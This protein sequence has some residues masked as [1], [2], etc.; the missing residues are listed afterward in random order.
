VKEASYRDQVDRL[1]A[2]RA[3]LEKR[4]AEALRAAARLEREA[5]RIERRV[6]RTSDAEELERVLAEAAPIRGQARQRRHE[7]ARI[8]KQ[9]AHPQETLERVR[10]TRPVWRTLEGS[11]RAP[12]A[13]RSAA[14]ASVPRRVEPLRARLTVLFAAADPF[15]DYRLA[16]AQEVETVGDRLQVAGVSDRVALHQVCA[17]RTPDL[18]AALVGLRPQVLHLSGHAA[19]GRQVAFLD[20]QGTMKRLP[21]RAIGATLATVD[22]EIEIV[23]LAPSYAAAGA[24]EIAEQVPVVIALPVQIGIEAERAFAAALYTALGRGGSISQGFDH[25]RSALAAAGIPSSRLP[26]LFT[27]P[28]V[29]AEELAL[30][31]EPPHGTAEAA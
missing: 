24:A 25:A 20:A 5:G 10:R 22:D 30:V 2:A 3:G 7:A 12:I 6:K 21:G 19:S 26:R 9:L 15:G 18:A 8:E 28:D 17:V 16:L 4:R 31:R 14:Q 27:R 29:R 11:A 23:V 1:E 13:A